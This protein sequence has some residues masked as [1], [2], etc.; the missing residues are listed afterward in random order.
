MAGIFAQ[1]I[2]TEDP[3]RLQDPL[4]IYYVLDSDVELA[5][6]LFLHPFTGCQH[7]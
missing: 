7:S 1:T 5:Y 3:L 2:T 4:T 6:K